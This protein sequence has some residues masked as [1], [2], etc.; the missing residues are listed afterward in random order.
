[1]HPRCC[2]YRPATS[3]V[4]CLCYLYLLQW[5][6]SGGK[7][8]LCL[9]KR[10]QS[11][12]STISLQDQ[13]VNA[14]LATSLVCSQNRVE[15]INTRFGRIQKC[16]MVRTVGECSN[17]CYSK[18]YWVLSYHS[19]PRN[20]SGCDKFQSVLSPLFSKPDL[21]M[22]SRQVTRAVRYFF[23]TGLQFSGTFAPL[24]SISFLFPR[25]PARVF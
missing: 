17:H 1:M 5:F 23:V 11:I 18:R 8:S 10:Q 6:V 22:V 25:R 24:P 19:V 7:S 13:L 2:R 15:D 21:P 20:V 16:L 14:V 3:W 4:S 9:G 12:N